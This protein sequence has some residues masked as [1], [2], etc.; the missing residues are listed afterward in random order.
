M[1]PSMHPVGWRSAPTTKE[2]TRPITR[3]RSSSW[4]RSRRPPDRLPGATARNTT[5]VRTDMTR[6]ETRV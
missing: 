5:A 1:L 4:L 3:S 6:T 2:T